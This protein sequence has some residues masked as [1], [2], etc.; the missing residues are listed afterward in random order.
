[1]MKE[2][3][4]SFKWY[5]PG[6]KLGAF[7]DLVKTGALYDIK[8]RKMAI[9]IRNLYGKS[10]EQNNV[11]LYVCLRGLFSAEELGNLSFGYLGAAYGY[12]EGFLKFGAGIYQI[13]S[14]TSSWSYIFSYFDDP[15][16]SK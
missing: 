9:S 14:N 12:S 2:Y 4:Q 16:D 15:R 8:T 5:E 1:M 7:I 13:L 10:C 11:S 6:I 3:G